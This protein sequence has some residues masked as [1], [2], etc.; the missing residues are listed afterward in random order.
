[1]ATRKKTIPIHFDELKMYFNE[2]YVIDV[3]SARGQV[4]L[5]Q[6]SIDEIVKIG[7]EKFYS[8]LNIF[9]TNTTENRLSLW[10]KGKDWNE[11]SDYELFMCLYHNIDQ[12]V[13]NLLFDNIQFKNGDEE[14][15]FLSKKSKESEEFTLY[16]E[17]LDVEID[18]QVY[19]QFAQYFRKLFN[20]YPKEKFTSSK[21][22]KEWYIEADRSKA[23]YEKKKE[24]KP[25]SILPLIS[26]CV[27]HPGFKYKIEELRELTIYQFMDSVNRLQIYESSTALLKGMYAGFIS[28][29]DIDTEDYNFMKEIK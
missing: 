9:V 4:I 14:L 16:S 8:T 7:Q 28:S 23:A 15:F 13:A 19:N 22:M 2:P 26:S 11:V 25:Y 12:D 29:K 27:N 24:K 18:E 17:T 10:D 6:P 20:I 5:R 1:M 21:T 3:E